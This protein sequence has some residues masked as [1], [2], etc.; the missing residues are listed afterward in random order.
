[1]N[2]NCT[3]CTFVRRLWKIKTTHQG[4]ATHNLRTMDIWKQILSQQ[5]I[6]H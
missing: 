5:R 4:V 2:K 1:M 3:E 6:R